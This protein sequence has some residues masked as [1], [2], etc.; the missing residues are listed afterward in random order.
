MC[1]H[2]GVA[3]KLTHKEEKIFKQGLIVDSLRGEHSTGV[4]AVYK[5]SNPPEISKQVG[6]PFE[7]L[8]DKR[9]D[10]ALAAPLRVLI[11]HNRY[12]TMGKID[13]YNAH[14]FQFSHIYGAHNGTLRSWNELEGYKDFQVDSQ[15]LFH[16]ISLHGVED[17]ISSVTG[18]WALVWW[19]DKA[20]ELNFLRNKERTFYIAVDKDGT[21]MFW[22]SEWEMLQL[23]LNRN[24]VKY[25]E[26]TPLEED[27]WL[28]FPIDRSGDIGK[29]IAKK[30]VGKKIVP[31]NQTVWR[32]GNQITPSNKQPF[33]TNNT[34]APKN[35]VP[36]CDHKII[37]DNVLMEIGRRQLDSRKAAY[38]HCVDAENPSVKIRLYLKPG[39]EFKWKEDFIIVGRIGA[40]TTEEGGYYKVV[41]STVRT[42]STQEQILYDDIM[43][44]YDE[45]GTTAIDYFP[46][47]KG[48]LL[49][50]EEWE[51]KYPSCAWCSVDL[52][53]EDKNYISKDGDAVCP[54]CSSNSEVR[55]YL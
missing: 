12:A 19:D 29:P 9:F 48:V 40:F 54:D 52:N 47:H 15:A 21:N 34:S 50:K 45:V 42:G 28:R 26:I 14:P 35:V 46:D 43:R 25:K 32:G 13:K 4:C 31:T 3:G 11:G 10:K 1:G 7:L 24:N 23:I 33:S 6:G 17:A 2:I 27:I 16:H 41:H 5:G 30:V 8:N 20:Q 22:A 38:V 44:R 18:A 36:K 39:D 51:T 37:R 53:A 55:A 49:T